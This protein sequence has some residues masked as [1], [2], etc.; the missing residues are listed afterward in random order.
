MRDP[1]GYLTPLHFAACEGRLDKIKR[2]LA[3]NPR[4][5]DVTDRF[6]MTPLHYAAMKNQYDA[7]VELVNKG[8]T[9]CRDADGHGPCFYAQNHSKLRSFLVG[10]AKQQKLKHL[11]KAAN[12]GDLKKIKANITH[13]EVEDAEQRTAILHAAKGRKKRAL[14]YLLL[15]GADPYV[16]DQYSQNII[17][18]TKRNFHHTELSRYLKSKIGIA[19]DKLQAFK[20]FYQ[21][22]FAEQ[23]AIAKKRRKK[24]IV[25]LGEIHGDYR[26]Y[27]LEKKLL[28]ALSELGIRHL[29]AETRQDSK[30]M[31]DS[32]QRMMKK[33][34]EPMNIHGVDNHPQ[35]ET[36]N[37]NQRNQYIRKGI[38]EVK[39]HG[40]MITG[41]HHLYGLVSRRNTQLDNKKFHIVAMNLSAAF[42]QRSSVEKEEK[43]AFNRKKVVQVSKLK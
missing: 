35:R 12:R 10:V 15:K 41:T 25:L 39:Q 13:I 17:D 21:K 37:L 5:V 26:I 34:P 4:S 33:M 31:L 38:E 11:H 27:Q 18:Y 23:L 43:F 1:N 28:T 14:D 3:R 40:V 20:E 6:G 22:F 9:L 32:Y 36:A 8:A 16:S 42:E 2:L 30:E 24:L 7:A 29:F 19:R